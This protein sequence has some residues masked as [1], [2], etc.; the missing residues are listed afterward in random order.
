MKKKKERKK[1]KP[2]DFNITLILGLSFRCDKNRS[3]A[4]D[5]FMYSRKMETAQTRILGER[6]KLAYSEC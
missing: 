4:L 2:V 5:Q 1:E 3:S 6:P